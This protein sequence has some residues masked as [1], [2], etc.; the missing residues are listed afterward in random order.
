MLRRRRRGRNV[1]A[2]PVDRTP[3][4]PPASSRL[5]ADTPR[6]GAFPLI[7]LL[8]LAALLA[9]GWT[10]YNRHAGETSPAPTIPVNPAPASPS[11]PPPK[12]A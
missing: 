7:W 3:Q 2:D 5:A 11:P 9:F 8:V 6:K 4:D 1:M 12:P 10:L